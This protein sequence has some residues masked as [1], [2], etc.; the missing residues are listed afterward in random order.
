MNASGEWDI[1]SA[2]LSLCRVGMNSSIVFWWKKPVKITRAQHLDS[3]PFIVNNWHICHLQI[4]LHFSCFDF[5]TVPKKLHFQVPPKKTFLWGDGGGGGG[6]GGSV[7]LNLASDL[8]HRC[9]TSFLIGSISTALLHTVSSM[10]SAGPFSQI[11]AGNQAYLS[12]CYALHTKLQRPWRP[13][14][15]CMIT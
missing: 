13:F 2:Y 4:L 9:L 5:K 1:N 6:E 14:T 7:P 3:V 15:F 12:L 10:K 11:A 8:F